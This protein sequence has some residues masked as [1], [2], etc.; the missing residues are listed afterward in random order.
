MQGNRGRD[1]KPELAL[2]RELHRRGLRYF[3]NRRPVPDLPRT[4]DVLFPR[5]RIAVFVDGCFWHGCPQHHTVAKANAAFWAA[6]VDR[7]RERDQE[8]TTAL[9]LAG[10]T[11]VRVWEHESIAF[12]ADLVEAAI[13]DRLT[14]RRAQG[15]GRGAKIMPG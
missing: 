13:R 2:R 9:E 6:K 10:W 3:V 11:V 8:T 7:T 15:Y 14:A 5:A 12:A 1:T 4:A